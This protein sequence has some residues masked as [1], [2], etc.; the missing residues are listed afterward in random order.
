MAGTHCLL[1]F[2][3]ACLFYCGCR[4]MF[5]KWI[6]WPLRRCRLLLRLWSSSWTVQ[7]IMA[8]LRIPLSGQFWF[9]GPVLSCPFHVYCCDRTL[10]A[11]LNY[12]SFTCC[13]KNWHAEEI[14]ELINGGSSYLYYGFEIFGLP[15]FASTKH[16]TFWKL[17]S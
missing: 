1:V 17:L 3:L 2:L 16:H 9:S 6:I 11:E 13:G 14:G 5:W 7:K 12:L 15:W 8:A 10:P 4:Q